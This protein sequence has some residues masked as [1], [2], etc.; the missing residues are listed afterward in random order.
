MNK[1]KHYFSLTTK[2]KITIILILIILTIC[3]SIQINHYVKYLQKD[4]L[5]HKFIILNDCVYY[6]DETYSRI[7]Y[8]NDEFTIYKYNKSDYTYI[9][10]YNE[11]K[12]HFYDIIYGTLEN[13]IKTLDTNNLTCRNTFSYNCYKIMLSSFYYTITNTCFTYNNK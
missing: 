2:N 8:F 7:K 1:N 9:Y 4:T 3:N 12:L 13:H 11:E 6:G 5:I 10:Y